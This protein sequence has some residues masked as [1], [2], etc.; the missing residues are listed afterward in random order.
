MKGGE[1]YITGQKILHE[2]DDDFASCRSDH[3]DPHNDEGDLL[4]PDRHV[5]I[6]A[7]PVDEDVKGLGDGIHLAHAVKHD[8]D[9]GDEDLPDAVDGEEIAEEVEVSALP[10]GGPFVSLPHVLQIVRLR[11]KQKTH[12]PARYVPN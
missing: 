12:C 1:R 9:G 7:E 4:G 6:D 3:N 2:K 11:K 5:H 8:V 10:R